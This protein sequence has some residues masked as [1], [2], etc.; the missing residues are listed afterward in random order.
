MSEYLK[1]T[2]SIVLVTYLVLGGLTWLLPEKFEPNLG[3]GP[4]PYDAQSY[5]SASTTSFTLGATSARLL[6][7]STARGYAVITNNSA[8]NMYLNFSDIAATANNGLLIT[9]SS[10]YEID[11]DNLYQG[12]ITGISPSGDISVLITEFRF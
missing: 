3:G 5:L 12:A 8:E 1:K 2:V 9:A 11:T 7:T 10:T 4:R 6:A